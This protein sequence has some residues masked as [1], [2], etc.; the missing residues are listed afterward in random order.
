MMRH[1]N[2][3]IGFQKIPLTSSP[4]DILVEE[5]F[6]IAERIFNPCYITGMNAANYWGLTEQIFITT[7]VMTQKMV[8]NRTQVIADNEYKIH[9]IKSKYFFGLK[10]IWFDDVK[11]NIADPSRLILDMLVFPD[12]CGGIRFCI[13]VFKN[14]IKS[15]KKDLILLQEYILKL[16]NYA[17]IKRLGFITEK[18]FK[19][20]ESL[21][22]FC[23]D[24]I[25]NDNTKKGIIKIDPLLNC[26]VEIKKWRLLI[27]KSLDI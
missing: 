4:D 10:S 13:E 24:C 11:V 8:R 7:T 1:I 27:P 9:T 12:F 2:Y 6:V 26:N 23:Y 21:I 20:E 3:F 25:N 22:K 17:A 14:Y 19:E 15:D 18:Y 16:K 5:P